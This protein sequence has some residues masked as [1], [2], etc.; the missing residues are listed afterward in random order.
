[1][2][3]IGGTLTGPMIFILP[4]LFYRRLIRMERDFDEQHE[5]ETF[6]RQLTIA[7]SDDDIFNSDRE[8]QQLQRRNNKHN[9]HYSG[10]GG[11][12]DSYGTFEKQPNRLMPR[13]ECLLCFCNDS[14]ICVSVIV[15]GLIVTITSTYFNV[16]TI[17]SNFDD[18]R[19]PC[20]QNISASFAELWVFGVSVF[21]FLLCF[22]SFVV[23]FCS[24]CCF[25]FSL[26]IKKKYK[27]KQK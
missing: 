14:L 12:V 27:Q 19:S 2:G 23:F 10:G 24:T 17:S 26:T 21:P 9:H 25:S 13:Q 22:V 3:I 5:R 8:Q 11:I 20:I 1:M 6:N 15:F 4:P 7:T 16:M 18:F